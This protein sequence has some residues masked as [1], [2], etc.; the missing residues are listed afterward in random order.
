MRRKQIF[1]A[2]ILEQSANQV[3]SEKSRP[4]GILYLLVLLVLLA[5]LVAS[6]VIHL[7]VHV[8]TSGIIK[9]REDHTVVL[10][11]TSGF[12]RARNLTLNAQVNAGDTLAVIRSELITARLPALEKRRE[13]LNVLISDLTQLTSRNPGKVKLSSPLYRQDVVYYL[14]QLADVESRR[15]QAE[16]AYARARKLHEASVIPLTE[17]ESAEAEYTL[18]QHAVKSLTDYNKR[19]WQGDLTNYRNELNDIEAQV[20]QISIQDAETVITSPVSGTIQRVLTLFDGTYVTAG[21]QLVEL[22]PNGRLIAECYVTPKDVGYL[23]SGMKGRIQVS[24]FPYTEWGVLQATV[25]EVFDD[26]TVSSDGTRSF[27]KVYCSLDRDYLTLKNGYTGQLK[28]G[29]AIGVNFLVTRRTIF[30]LV[31][32]KLDDWLNPNHMNDYE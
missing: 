15:D 4:A 6:S 30:Q 16:R 32:D 26:I 8:R 22:S 11:T 2:S 24:S 18:A 3:L 27:Y 28:K 1:P 31:Y 25:E 9:P 19:Q 23:H 17:L 12:V 7:D 29:M 21:Q 13:E 20:E 14:A 10:A 5:A